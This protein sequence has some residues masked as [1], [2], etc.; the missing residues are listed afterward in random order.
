MRAVMIIRIRRLVGVFFG[1]CCVVL[2]FTLVF[3][4]NTTLFF[5]L[6]KEDFHPEKDGGGRGWGGCGAGKGFTC[7][8]V[9][10]ERG[11]D[12]KIGE[13]GWVVYNGEVYFECQELE[14]RS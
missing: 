9:V 10:S 2:C 6:D 8:F 5:F 12:R 7:D 3:L 14:V 4:L 13:Y 1:F 11:A